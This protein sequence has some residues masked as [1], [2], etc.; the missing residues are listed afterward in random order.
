MDEFLKQWYG[1]LAFVAFDFVA[2]LVV[3]CITYRWFF[4]RVCDFFIS[5]VA[6]VLLSPLYLIVYFRARTARKKSEIDKILQKEPFVGK[7]GKR[8]WLHTFACEEENGYCAWLKKTKFYALPRLFDVFLGTIS[9]IGCK[10]FAESDCVF[11]SDEEEDRHLAKI[12]LINPLVKTGDKETDYEEMLLSDKKYA[13][14][15]SFFGDVKI[16]FVWLLKKI[17]G[18]G[19]EYLGQTRQCAY[20]KYL[21][22]EEQITQADYDEAMAQDL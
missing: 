1:I 6:L 22:Q 18:E 19:N 4:K 7:K 21:L 2:L 14:S 20:A 11:L 10:P 13:R 17:R 9:F 15:Y 12:G 5:L 16:F 3:V 8:V